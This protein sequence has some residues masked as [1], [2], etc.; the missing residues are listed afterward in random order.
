MTLCT[1]NRLHIFGEIVDG[2]MV[3]NELGSMV[4]S[5]WTEIPMHFE[6]IQLDEFMIMPNHI[7]GIICIVGARHAVPLRFETF[8]K[9]VPGSV[10]TIVR[11][12]K[13]AVT[14]HIN[15]L[16]KTTRVTVWQR[17]YYDRVIRNEK[18]L[19]EIREYIVNNPIKWELDPENI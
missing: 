11:S 2:Q 4:Q 8:G 3:L 6:N 19:N 9:P 14:K 18:E 12:F 16:R 1:L 15:E 7:H 17:N 5:C 10:P 13:S